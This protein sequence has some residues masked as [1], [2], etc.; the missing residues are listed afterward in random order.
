MVENNFETC[1]RDAAPLLSGWR[2]RNNCSREIL[3]PLCPRVTL[4]LESFHPAT[5]SSSPL[6]LCLPLPVFPLPCRRLS[7]AVAILVVTPPPLLF[8]LDAYTVNLLMEVKLPYKPNC[9]C[10]LVVE[11]Q[12]L[13][14]FRE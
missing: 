7:F 13:L 8:L 6:P 10:R 14:S 9:P 12:R 1:H 11:F 3:K 4:A 5:P 2:L